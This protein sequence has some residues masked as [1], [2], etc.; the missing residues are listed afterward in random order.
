[1]PGFRWRAD[2]IHGAIEQGAG[3]CMRCIVYEERA[4]SCSS[5]KEQYA[6]QPAKPEHMNAFQEAIYAADLN[7]LG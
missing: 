6:I 4:A 5:L 3:D 1:M 7:K 2:S